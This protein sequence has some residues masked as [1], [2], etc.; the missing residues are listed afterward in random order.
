MDLD[1]HELSINFFPMNSKPA[2]VRLTT[3]NIA[4]HLTKLACR[5]CLS[6][7]ENSKE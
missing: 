6:E 2:R 1:I 7:V 3:R 5:T 4:R